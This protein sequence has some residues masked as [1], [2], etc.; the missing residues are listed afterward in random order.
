ML[1]SLYVF[2]SKYLQLQLSSH[3]Q[4]SKQFLDLK[5]LHYFLQVYSYLTLA[6]RIFMAISNFC[7]SK[8]CRASCSSVTAV[9]LLRKLTVWMMKWLMKVTDLRWL[10]AATCKFFSSEQREQSRN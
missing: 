4:F 8:L 1:I 6:S 7:S 10:S 2:A 9:K 5:A 3:L